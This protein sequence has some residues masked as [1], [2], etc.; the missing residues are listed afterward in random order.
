MGGLA[1]TTPSAMLF[2]SGGPTWP[3]CQRGPQRWCYR[4][5][6]GLLLICYNIQLSYFLPWFCSRHLEEKVHPCSLYGLLEDLLATRATPANY[7]AALM[8]N[9]G[10]LKMRRRRRRK[11]SLHRGN[12]KK[13]RVLEQQHSADAQALEPRGSKQSMNDAWMPCISLLR[14]GARKKRQIKMEDKLVCEKGY[15]FP[16]AHRWSKTNNEAYNLWVTSALLYNSI[17]FVTADDYFIIT[18]RQIKKLSN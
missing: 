17:I 15:S 1:T 10:S 16:Q 11:S 3:D 9:T 7:W 2:H 6:R 4:V 12:A 5:N 8:G 13:C 18:Q 14:V